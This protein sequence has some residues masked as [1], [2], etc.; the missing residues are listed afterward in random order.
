[1]TI[2]NQ[3]AADEAAASW[4]LVERAQAGDLDAF[5]E[6][7]GRNRDH[8][9]NLVLFKVGGRRQVAED[10]TSE[11]FVRALRGIHRIVWQGR[12]VRAW[13]FTI[14]KNLITDHCKSAA[15]NRTVS[16]GGFETDD[17]WSLASLGLVSSVGPGDVVEHGAVRR[18]LD[19]AI[20]QL[21]P[22]QARVIRLRWL[23]GLSVG[24]AAAAIGCSIGAV[25][26]AQYRGM[27]M[28]ARNPALVALR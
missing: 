22:D 13:L 3:R 4:L 18:A 16:T 10:I 28:L 2:P 6:I 17:I 21:T 27:R 19:E 11:T 12:D 25:K 5:G 15:V 9:F 14:A 1:M 23:Q 24:E 8:V 7:Y 26:A 20:G